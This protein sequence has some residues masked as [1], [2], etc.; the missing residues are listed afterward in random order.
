M[1]VLNQFLDGRHEQRRELHNRA[2]RTADSGSAWIDGKLR[3]EARLLKFDVW[4]RR[5]LEERLDWSWAGSQKSRRIEQCRIYLERIV[6]GLWR[7]GW[8]LD[9]A[10]L[11][12]HLVKAIEAVG[13]QQRAGKVQSFWPY[14][15][16]A[17]DRYVGSNAEELK[18]QALRAGSHVAQAM[19][20]IASLRA[21]TLPELAAQRAGE[22]SGAKEESLRARQ[23]KERR[24]QAHNR[25]VADQPRL[26]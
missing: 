15:Q 14:F 10:A 20:V 16:A 8:M 9:G 6:L 19:A 18:E 25:A 21:P 26:F 13:A 1:D 4:V 2:I 5:Q 23:S 22:V 12:E 11:A 3:P 17:V 24:L 7:R